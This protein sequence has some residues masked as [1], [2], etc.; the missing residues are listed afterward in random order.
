[1]PANA[2]SNG[3]PETRS[4]RSAL[5]GGGRAASYPLPRSVKVSSIAKL[6]AAKRRSTASRWASSPRPLRPREAMLTQKQAA[7]RT[8]RRGRTSSVRKP[9][10]AFRVRRNATQAESVHQPIVTASVR[11]VETPADRARGEADAVTI[12][13]ARITHAEC[14]VAARRYSD[15]S[16][17]SD[18]RTRSDRRRGRTGQRPPRVIDRFPNGSPIASK[19]ASPAPDTIRTGSERRLRTTRLIA[20]SPEPPAL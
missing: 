16:P 13:A 8:L 4:S 20:S 1:M 15:G 9:Q 2:S 18:L 19:G 7:T 6:R 10:R 17:G 12:V 3:S 5:A 11:S 14:P